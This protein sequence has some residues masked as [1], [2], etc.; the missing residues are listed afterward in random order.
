MA[1]AALSPSN[2]KIL[3]AYAERTPGSARLAA[4]ARGTF[5]SGVTHDARYLEPYPVYIARAQGSRKWDVDGHEYVD[6]V[7]G[8]GA[9][10][11][12][13]NYPPVQEA[14]QRQLRLG[15]HYGSSHELEI[16]WG[17]LVRDLVPSAERVRFTNSG[18]EATLLALRLARAHTG[19][20]KVVRFTGHFHGWHDHLTGGYMSHFDGSAPAGISPVVMGDILRAPPEDF[21]ATRVLIESHNDIA[22]VIIE[23]TGASFG[24]TPTRPE[25]LSALRELTREREIVLIF[26]EVISGFR[27]SPGGAQDYYG[28]T[29]ELTTLAKVLAGGL[30]GGAVAG[31]EDIMGLLDFMAARA[32]GH[33][34]ILHFGTFNANPLS[35]AAGVAALEVV[36]DGVPCSAAND[37]AKVLRECLNNILEEEG[38]PWAVYGTFSAFHVFTNPKMRTI[39]PRDFDPTRHNYAELRTALPA[40]VQKLRLGML[41]GGV[42]LLGWPGGVISAA[43][44]DG[45]LNRTV[46]AF[47]RTL[48]VLREEKDFPQ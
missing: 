10:L 28:I 16:R 44:D 24:H 48:R 35:A 29:P 3:A 34:K 6:Y 18:T 38:V 4:R 8:H 19:N 17:E 42:D 45:D 11:L 25:F 7:G 15:T 33:E 14:V 30:P 32:S 27:V 36:A 31:R 21:E 1:D 2:S 23:P 5:P 43:H 47:R 9:L 40:V 39:R 20:L 46:E 26:D 37:F 41:A 13:H 12:G 22:A